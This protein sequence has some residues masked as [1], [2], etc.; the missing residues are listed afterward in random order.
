MVFFFFL[1]VRRGVR[2]FEGGTRGNLR[3]RRRSFVL[4]CCFERRGG[5]RLRVA[6]RET[7]EARLLRRDAV[8][9]A[10]SPLRD[11]RGA[12]VVSAEPFVRVAVEPVEAAERERRSLRGVFIGSPGVASVEAGGEALAQRRA[13]PLGADGDGAV[14]AGGGPRCVSEERGA[15]EPR[16]RRERAAGLAAREVR[17]ARVHRVA[18]FARDVPG[19]P[20]GAISAACWLA[21]PSPPST[22]RA[23]QAS[24]R[25]RAPPR[26]RDT[27]EPRAAS[28]ASAAS[29]SPRAAGAPPRASP[30]PERGGGAAGARARG[31]PLFVP[32]ETFPNNTLLLAFSICLGCWTGGRFHRRT[33]EPPLTSM[34]KQSGRPRAR[35]MGSHEATRAGG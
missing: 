16:V 29:E 15:S 21:T 30:I 28:A 32:N 34:G 2:R 18:R 24:R 20:R 19:E 25:A 4:F 27:R 35:R 33:S 12:Q 10:P 22:R 7:I 6:P 11:G 17:L 5:W 9:A 8:D 1:E 14:E 26:A 31:W 13:A 23:E 3:L